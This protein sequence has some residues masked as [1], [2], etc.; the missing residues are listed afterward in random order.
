MR[1]K[2]LKWLYG[3][4]RQKKHALGVAEY[5]PNA[6]R[7]EIESLEQVIELIEWIIGKVMEGE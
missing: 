3:M 5:K 1:D 6:T 4:L 7:A 2:A